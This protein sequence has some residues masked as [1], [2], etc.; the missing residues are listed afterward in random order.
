MLGDLFEASA[1]SLHPDKAAHR[2]TLLDEYEAGAG[3]L[4]RFAGAAPKGCR[5]HWLHGNHDD[6]IIQTNDPRR[7]NSATREMLRWDY[8]PFAASFAK[9]KQYPYRKPSVHSQTGLL[10]IGQCVFVHGYQAGLTSDN[11]EAKRI[12]Y[13]LGGIPHLLVVRGHTHRPQPV[14]QC[15]DSGRT[16]HCWHA[17]AGTLGP[18]NPPPA[19]MQRKDTN[20]WGSAIVVGSCKLGRTRRMS[21]PEWQARTIAIDD[22]DK[23]NG[24]KW[25]V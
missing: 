14:T 15:R 6:N 7:S 3:I 12:R 5:L 24:A 20:E 19:F 21:E 4:D 8:S 2:H 1:V 18:I 9:W 11:S 13:A 17:N 16:V 10:K 22:L 25:I 23:K